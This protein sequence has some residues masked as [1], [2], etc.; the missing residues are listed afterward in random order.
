MGRDCSQPY[1]QCLINPLQDRVLSVRENARFQG[2]PDFYK[3]C[4]STKENYMIQVGNA[5]AVLVE[6][7]LSYALGM[8]SQGLC[9]DEPVIKIPFNYPQCLM[10]HGN[11]KDHSDMSVGKPFDRLLPKEEENKS[12][13]IWQ[14]LSTICSP[15]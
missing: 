2:F 3:L 8:A 4:L 10:M 7:A 13:V 5:V 11:S 12:N 9:D 1:N 6:I 14:E 15:F